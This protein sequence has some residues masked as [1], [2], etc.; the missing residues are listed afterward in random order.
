MKD[1]QILRPGVCHRVPQSHAARRGHAFSATF[2]NHPR[3]VPCLGSALSMHLLGRIWGVLPSF[4][5]QC[6]FGKQSKVS[7]TNGGVTG[8][9]KSDVCQVGQGDFTML[10]VNGG[11]EQIDLGEEK[12]VSTELHAVG[13]GT[14]VP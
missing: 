11:M 13:L 4:G 12:K 10:A 7:S 5:K 14:R 2:R 3:T 8:G 1:L 6:W 9:S